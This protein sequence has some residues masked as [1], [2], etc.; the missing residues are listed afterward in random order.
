MIF[1][2]SGQYDTH[3]Y[4]TSLGYTFVG[5]TAESGVLYFANS[6]MLAPGGVVIAPNGMVPS[7]NTAGRPSG[8]A[9]IVGYNFTLARLEAFDGT[10]W[11]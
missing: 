8:P 1:D 9:G 3:Q 6:V 2:W 4:V 5:S 11:Y 7:W 10:T